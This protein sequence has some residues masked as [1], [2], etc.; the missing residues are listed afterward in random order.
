MN[1]L[2]KEKEWWKTKTWNLKKNLSKWA[3]TGINMY[4]FLRIYEIIYNSWNENDYTIWWGPQWML[5]KYLRWLYFRS[6]KGERTYMVISFLCFMQNGE[7]LIIINCDNLHMYIVLTRA[8]KK[9]K[10]IIYLQKH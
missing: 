8:T 7:T 10:Q 1:V 5:R 2:Y 3:N 9:T 4:T 6:R